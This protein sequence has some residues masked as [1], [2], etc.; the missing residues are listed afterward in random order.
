MQQS[1]IIYEALKGSRKALKL[2]IISYYL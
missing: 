1:D 2:F